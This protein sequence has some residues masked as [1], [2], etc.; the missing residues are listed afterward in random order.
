MKALSTIARSTSSSGLALPTT[1]RPWLVATR[2]FARDTGSAEAG[3]S[4]RRM[5]VQPQIA[6]IRRF[7]GG[8]HRRPRRTAV[9]RALAP[10][11]RVL[12]S[13]T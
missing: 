7:D 13:V 9:T 4:P 12:Q 6:Q 11:G 3:I 2:P 5:A 8:T 1:I 10:A